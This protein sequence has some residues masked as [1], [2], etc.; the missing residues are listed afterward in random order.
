M[1]AEL[2]F[3]KTAESKANIWSV[4]LIYPRPP[5]A[6]AAVC[7]KAVALLLL[8]HCLLLLLLLFSVGGMFGHCFLVRTA[9]SVISS[10][11]G[12]FTLFVY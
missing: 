5:L 4:K 6:L 9:L 11:A 2:Y 12:C 10:R 1:G 3:L 7:S 8:I